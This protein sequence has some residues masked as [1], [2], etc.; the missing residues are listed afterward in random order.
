[1]SKKFFSLFIV[2]T[3]I[4]SLFANVFFGRWLAAKISTMSVLNRFKILSPQAPIVIN[5]QQIIRSSDTADIAQATQQVKSKLSSIVAV[6]AD[7]SI[8]VLGGAVNITSDGL[9]VTSGNVLSQTTTAGQKYVV[10]LSDGTTAP[11]ETITPDAASG[12]VFVRA[13]ALSVAPATLASSA[14]LSAGEKILFV[15]NSGQAFMS[16]IQEGVVSR[17]QADVQGIIYDA[18]K[19]SRSFAAQIP[20]GLLSGTA[21]VNLSGQV[22]GIYNGTTIISADVISQIISA[23]LSHNQTIIHPVFGFTYQIITSNQSNLA[24]IPQGAKVME[25]SK[26]KGETPSLQT[27]DIILDVDGVTISESQ[28]LE[29]LLAKYKK[30][31]VVALDVL[32]GKQQLSASLKVQ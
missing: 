7:G 20:T 21:V 17:A 23:Y 16:R 2:I 18:D 32:R 28:P 4:V 1:M 15:V 6:E 14:N 12:L 13:N 9:F 30:G 27:G 19:S 11:I 31:D 29:S 25:V 5:N 3:V 26:L 22:V 10:M 24:G 8:A